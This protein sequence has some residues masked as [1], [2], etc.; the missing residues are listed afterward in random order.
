MA[1]TACIMIFFFIDFEA[2]S[3]EGARGLLYVVLYDS[4]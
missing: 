4:L 1:V 2:Q 3:R